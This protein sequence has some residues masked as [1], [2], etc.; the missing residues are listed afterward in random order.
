M[1]EANPTT[2]TQSNEVGWVEGVGEIWK[3]RAINNRHSGLSPP[4]KGER[5]LTLRPHLPPSPSQHKIYEERIDM[6]I[7][8]I[9]HLKYEV[10]VKD[11]SKLKGVEKKGSGF[12]CVVNENTACI[13]IENLKESSIML[14]RIP[15]IAH[16][17]THV[18]QII[19]EKFGMKM[20]NE[21]EHTAYLMSYILEE[22]LNP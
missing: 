22:I 5:R 11:M 7:I 20:E 2:N 21:Q 16:E 13:F 3:A 15:H 9:P 8:K 1:V 19:C 18:L 6:K 12:T 4:P 10:W 14:E 17:V